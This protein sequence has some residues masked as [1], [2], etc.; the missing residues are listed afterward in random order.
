[1]E[2]AWQRYL[3]ERESA[4][5]DALVDYLRIPSLSALREH[6]AD[7]DAA[8]EWTAEAMRRAGL[9]DVRLLPTDGLPVVVGRWRVDDRLPTALIYGHY[10]VQPV[11][12]LDLWESPPFEPA[13]RDDRIVARGA[14]DMKGNTLTALHAIEAFAKTTGQPPIN[15]AVIVEGEEE[16]GSPS[17]PAFLRDNRDL[18]ACDIVISA[19]GGMFGPETPSLTVA[20]K[21]LASCQVDLVTGQTDL[22]SGQFG[23]AVPN[24]ARAIAEVVAA[25]HDADGRVT[26]PGFY[27]RV[28]D[29]T[30][31]DRRE[32]AAVPFDEAELRR[33]AG[34]NALVGEAGYTPQES[35]WARPTLDINGIWGGFAGEGTKTVTPCQAHAK[36]TCRLVPDQDP[37][38]IL[39]LIERHLATIAPE[40]ATVTL[41]RFAGSARPFAIGRDHPALLAAR[42][43]LRESYGVEPL[44][45]RTGGTVPALALFKEVL[46]ADTITLGWSMPDCRA[47][48][49]N[50][51]YRL[52][53]YRRGTA[54]YARMLEAL[55]TTA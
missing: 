11:D 42:A 31:E 46:G 44:V 25:L 22:H 21:G 5:L 53:D 52:T 7:I 16:I 33:T 54:A 13:I 8:A 36:I 12:P 41:R 48:A 6:R 45:T 40:G 49:P 30:D 35:R 20:L 34:A 15:V 47:H 4:H 29:L 3:I 24:A 55:A 32:I 18:L 17:L 39:D 2:P 43:V 51:W 38:E 27:D 23:A 26:V 28:R 10:D 37:V 19:D 1:M 9:P 50:E 14:A